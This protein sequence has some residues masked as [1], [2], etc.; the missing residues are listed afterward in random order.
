MKLAGLLLS[1]FCGLDVRSLLGD[2]ILIIFWCFLLLAFSVLVQH[3][4]KNGGEKEIKKKIHAPRR[5]PSN[6]MTKWLSVNYDQKEG[7]TLAAELLWDCR[8][9]KIAGTNYVDK[10]MLT[11]ERSSSRW[12]SAC[13][14]IKLFN[15]FPSCGSVLLLLATFAQN[16]FT[17]IITG[18]SFP[19]F[20]LHVTVF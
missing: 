11:A 17:K 4:W 8:S 9:S 14:Y 15:F 18:L 16:T 5:R 12:K 6:I 1:F 2:Q 13:V 3:F 20:N 7:R 19:I 10:R